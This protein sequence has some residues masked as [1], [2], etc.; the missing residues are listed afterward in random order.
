VLGELVPLGH[1]KPFEQ[2]TR[3]L[4]GLLCNCDNLVAA[5]PDRC[6]RLKVRVSRFGCEALAP[7]V[8]KELWESSVRDPRGRE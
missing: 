8:R 6:V 5:S 1:A 4:I 7:F 2:S 3:T